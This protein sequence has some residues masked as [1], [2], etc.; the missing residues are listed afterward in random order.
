MHPPPHPP[1]ARAS[2][3]E[4]SE[5]CIDAGVVRGLWRAR[6]CTWKL[7]CWSRLGGMQYSLRACP[8]HKELTTKCQ[9]R[10]EGCTA[11]CSISPR[12]RAVTASAPRGGCPVVSAWMSCR[13]G[14]VGW[15]SECRTHE[16]GSEARKAVHFDT[17]DGQ[18]QGSRWGRQAGNCTRL[19]PLP[20]S[21]STHATVTGP[22]QLSKHLKGRS[23]AKTWLAHLHHA[24]PC[25]AAAHH[26]LHPRLAQPVLGQ[27]P[28]SA[29]RL[30][31][32]AHA[33]DGVLTGEGRMGRG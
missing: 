32:A 27:Q 18:P 6:W 13:V 31:I 33:Q 5:G 14:G 16:L 21:S 12:L 10:C 23:N 17:A 20:G 9:T 28:R 25:K 4:G 15:S 1:P 22:K 11:P 24:V 2:V 7:G 19:A 30:C 29:L 26:L 8:Q 3:A